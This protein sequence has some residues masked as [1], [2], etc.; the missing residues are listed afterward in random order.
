MVERETVKLRGDRMS[1]DLV[2]GRQGGDKEVEVD[3]G[4]I[5]YSKVVD[6]ENKTDRA[7]KM[8]EQTGNG[9][10]DKAKGRQERDKATVTQLTG[11]LKTVHGLVDPEETVPLAGRVD[12]DEGEERE[13][14][15]GLRRVRVDIDLNKLNG[16]ECQIEIDKVKIIKDSIFGDNGIE[17]T[18]KGS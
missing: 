11:F 10:F 2:Q 13:T 18:V 9:S 7:S 4:V 17:D 5:L 15:Q 6:D 16:E 3:L 8:T 1:L 14:G 12:L